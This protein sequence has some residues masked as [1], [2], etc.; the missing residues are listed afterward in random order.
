MGMGLSNWLGT[1]DRDQRRAG[2]VAALAQAI[3]AP[4]AAFVRRRVRDPDDADDILQDTW[5]RLLASEAFA[6]AAEP[7]AY[8][9]TT[10]ANLVRDRWRARAPDT[11]PVDAV[12]VPCP[13]P[14][15]ADAALGRERLALLRAALAELPAAER[16]A[17]VWHR[18]DGLS[19][20]AIAARLG[21]TVPAVRGAI[22][23]ALVHCARR[24][25]AA[26]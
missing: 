26:R 1:D 14:S 3:G 17:L 2:L 4:L 18:V 5:L 19:H 15:P 21:S 9:F 13:A 20:L 8:A 22:A 24:L 16:R 6:Q 7:E 12:E 11:V 10:A 23:R 25:R